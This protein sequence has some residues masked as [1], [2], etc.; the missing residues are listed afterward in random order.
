MVSQLQ[1]Q[2]EWHMGDGTVS[3][4]LEIRGHGLH[5]GKRVSVKIRPAHSHQGIIFRRMHAGKIQAELPAITAMRLG[6]PLCTALENKQ[7]WRVRTIE[8]LLAALLISGIDHATVELDAEEV[9]ILDGSA[10]PWLNLLAQGGRQETGRPRRFI[11]ILKSMQVQDEEGRSLRLEPCNNYVIDIR[12]DLRGFGEF[13]WEGI[14]TPHSFTEEIAPARSY[15]RLKWAVPAI[16]FGYLSGRPILRGARP[17]CTATILGNQVLGGM[18]RPQEF[19]RHRIVDLVGDLALL[20]A[21]IRGK[22]TAIRPC[23]EMNF[24]LAKTL[25]E[26]TD[27]WRWTHHPMSGEDISR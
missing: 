19:V 16:I 27:C 4:D 21:P 10:L 11:E 6:Q 17:S 13:H 15:G 24:Q 23:H 5:T 7:G 1:L 26:Q 3:R 12:N 20:G 18:R 8:H 2:P 22:V 14:I 25:Q 9:P